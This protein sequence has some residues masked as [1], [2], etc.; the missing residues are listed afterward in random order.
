MKP[1]VMKRQLILGILFFASL[2]GPVLSVHTQEGSEKARKSDT[3]QLRL[4][5]S[6]PERLGASVQ[7]LVNWLKFYRRTG[8]IE[9]AEKI[10]S[11]LFPV[12]ST[13]GFPVPPE[14]AT[15]DFSG[16]GTTLS[17]KM[18]DLLYNPTDIGVMTSSEN[19][20]APSIEIEHGGLAPN[21]FIAAENWYGASP[22]VIRIRKSGNHGLTWPSTIFVGGFPSTHPTIRQT[23]SS[24][25]GVIVA[26]TAVSGQDDIIFWRGPK[27]LSTSFVGTY[28]E[29]NNL[30][31]DRPSFASD[32]PSFSPP[33]IYVAYSE[34]SGTSYSVKFT[35]STDLGQSWS[36][37]PLTIASFAGPSWG[38][39]CA[40]S[41]AVDPVHGDIYVAYTY[42]Q[43][44]SEGIA[45]T[46]STNMGLAFP[47]PTVI[48]TADAKADLYPR[49]AARNGVASL[50]W[51]HAYSTTDHDIRYSYSDD[52]GASWNTSLELA[53]TTAE[54]RFPDIRESDIA[55]STRIYASYI[56]NEYQVVV[57]WCNTGAP[58][59][60][61]SE[62][63]VKQGT[64]TV[65]DDA[66]CIMPK[67]DTNGNESYST[68]WAELAPDYDICFNANWLPIPTV[69]VTTSPAGRQITVDGDPYTAPQTF[70]WSP[71]S[72]HTLAVASP[73]SGGTGIQYAYSSWSDGGAQS[74]TI[75]APGS[76][77]TYTA[78]FATQYRLTTAASPAAGGT[79]SPTTGWQTSGVSVPI[80]A[81]AAPGY[82]FT[83]WSG[84]LSGSTNPTSISMSGPR[85]VTASFTSLPTMTVTTSPA[86]RQIT[87]DGDPYTAPQTFQWSPGSS[88][89]LAV[90]SPQSGGTGIQ[91]VYSS[92]SDGGA[93]SHT[94][95]APGSNTT[96]TASL[97]PSTG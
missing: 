54:E 67:I 70:Q 52:A 4:V 21:M 15:L 47:A 46:R 64:N 39:D 25:I 29:A 41:V 97:L 7:R 73:Q 9:N 81:N 26:S 24:Q 16:V 40:T 87:V 96:Y 44:S 50:V 90:A 62:L 95:S 55:G 65:N 37:P 59:T 14:F 85:S 33:Y 5:F 76:N 36:N 34:K 72:S 74:H 77:T 91:Y 82:S 58:T 17:D 3:E 84:D 93:Q 48:T 42:W 79:V 1:I 18:A 20:K 32:Y 49:V 11:Q 45:I 43:G 57:R 51:E 30:M 22:N 92:W 75:S 38:I 78:S 10:A 27:D 71:G 69:T 86:G 63:F 23:S 61:Q 88:H 66:P 94:I 53:G 35:R 80:Q 12:E 83:G 8:D 89:T 31:H 56:K 68:A 6:E 19:E 13:M 28:V 60:W 2:L